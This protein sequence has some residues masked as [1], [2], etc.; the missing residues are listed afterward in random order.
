MITFRISG[1]LPAPWEDFIPQDSSHPCITLMTAENAER[2]GV[3]DG[4]GSDGWVDRILEVA[5][6]DEAAARATIAEIIGV[7]P[8]D[9]KIECENW[10]QSA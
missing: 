4:D 2:C 5:E 1:S 7:K 9:I 3:E 6:I 8:E 10:A